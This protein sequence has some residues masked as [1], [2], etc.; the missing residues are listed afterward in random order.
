ME[1]KKNAWNF[2]N[3]AMGEVGPF[4]TDYF[5]ILNFFTHIQKSIHLINHFYIGGNLSLVNDWETQRCKK[6]GSL[7]A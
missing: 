5:D 7:A 3:S 1:D 2:P 4:Q 6:C